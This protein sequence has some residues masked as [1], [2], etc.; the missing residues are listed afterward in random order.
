L[1][2]VNVAEGD[3]VPLERRPF[4][5]IILNHRQMTRSVRSRRA[6]FVPVLVLIASV[7]VPRAAG[8][9]GWEVSGGYSMLR[10]EK[11]QVTFPLGWTAGAALSLNRWL[12]V[13]ADVDGQRKAIPS[14]GSDIV[15]TSHAFLVGGRA[16]A[17]LGR[18][19]ESAQVCVGLFRA[20]GDAFGS[21]NSS[22]SFTVQPGLGLEYPIASRWS[23]RAGVDLRLIP[24]GEQARVTAAVVYR[25]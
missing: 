4:R 25:R 2:R 7:L 14:I 1:T 8:A 9:G 22:T 13:I 3:V 21:S 12:S 16:S 15:L 17:T 6:R 19:T 5:S 18:F 24:T 10:E 11:D 23:V 20:S